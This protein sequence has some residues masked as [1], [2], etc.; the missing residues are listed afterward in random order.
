MYVDLLLD[1][2]DH[3][4]VVLGIEI[5]EAKYETGVARDAGPQVRRNI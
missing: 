2:A 1:G 4:E 3:P 5:T